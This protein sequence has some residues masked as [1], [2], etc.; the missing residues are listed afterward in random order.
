MQRGHYHYTSNDLRKL[1]PILDYII[2]QSV[3]IVRI[4]WCHTCVHKHHQVWVRAVKVSLKVQILV[5]VNVVWRV[6]H[7]PQEWWG[8]IKR[9]VHSISSKLIFIH[10]YSIVSN[11][12]EA[13][14]V[15]VG[16]VVCS[17]G[18]ISDTSG[19]KRRDFMDLRV[20]SF[21]NTAN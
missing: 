18:R 1:L 13:S 2:G 14:K 4:G 19:K 11:K 3:K 17:I 5:Q 16:G 10:I 15:A 7:W 9:N 8:I 20:H 21:K 6:T 12:L